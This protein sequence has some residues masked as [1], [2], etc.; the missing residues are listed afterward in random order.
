MD[1]K[2]S[3]PAIEPVAIVP[4]GDCPDEHQILPS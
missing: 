3:S 1:W 4:D 2:L